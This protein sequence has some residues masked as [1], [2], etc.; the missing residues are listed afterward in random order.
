MKSVFFVVLFVAA[1][2]WAGAGPLSVFLVLIQSTG[3]IIAALAAVIVATIH[4]TWIFWATEKFFG[5]EG[6]KNVFL[7]H[8]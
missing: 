8:G 2:L 5:P 4:W 6:P 7:P 1:V 3:A